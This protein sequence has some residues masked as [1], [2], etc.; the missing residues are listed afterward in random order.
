MRCDAR[1]VSAED[2]EMA[3]SAISVSKFRFSPILPD[4]ATAGVCL[5]AAEVSRP[6]A[7][8]YAASPS[9]SS[10]WR[11]VITTPRALSARRLANDV[12]SAMTHDERDRRE[13]ESRARTN[14][15]KLEKQLSKGE[16]EQ[17]SRQFGH[18]PSRYQS[19]NGGQAARIACTAPADA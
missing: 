3:R 9:W 4:L 2:H 10:S 12:V 7:F 11:K 17:R 18:G 19:S 13:S 6:P 15:L 5:M 8:L 1:P 16:R 14:L